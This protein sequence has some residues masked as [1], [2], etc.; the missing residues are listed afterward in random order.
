MNYRYERKM[1]L[2]KKTN[3]CWLPI[4]Q[5]VLAARVFVYK[6][7]KLYEMNLL[8][9]C[10]YDESFKLNSLEWSLMNLNKC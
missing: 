10:Q 6:T 2:E 9:D 1:D 3:V 7:N 5:G 4:F 8:T